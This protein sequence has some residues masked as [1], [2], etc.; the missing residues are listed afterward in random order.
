MG[1]RRSF[2]PLPSFTC[3]TWVAKSTSVIVKPAYFHAPQSGGVE[4][5]QDRSVAYTSIAVQQHMVRISSISGSV[6]DG[7]GIR[8]ECLAIQ[9]NSLGLCSMSRRYWRRRKNPMAAQAVPLCGDIQALFAASVDQVTDVAA[10]Q[11]QIRQVN[12]MAIVEPLA[13]HSG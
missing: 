5:L 8:R 2:L 4:S 1:T 12:I 3:T 6:Q 7:Q 9:K 11:F 10:V 13:W